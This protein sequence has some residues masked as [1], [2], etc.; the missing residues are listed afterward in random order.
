MWRDALWPVVVVLSVLLAGI[1]LGIA[2]ADASP[3]VYAIDADHELATDRAIDEYHRDGVISQNLTKLYLTVT[4]A[5]THQDAG[6][7]GFHSNFNNQFICL[8]YRE[9]IPREVRV[10]IPRDYWWPRPAEKDS[11]TS[12]SPATFEPT[13]EENHT[14]ITVRFDGPERAC[15][16]VGKEAGFYFRN[17]DRLV[18]A[19]ND[20]TGWSLPQLG[21]GE[22]Q[23][24]Y[25]PDGVFL[26]NST[27]TIP[28]KGKDMTIQYAP[29]YGNET[30]PTWLP[31]PS[32]NDPEDQAVCQY[33]RDGR[34]ES[35]ELLVTDARAPTIRYKRGR[36]LPAQLEGWAN[37]LAAVPDRLMEFLRGIGG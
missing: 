36:D 31:V 27:H 19:V 9:T 35:V 7:D 34:A 28:T 23:W 33:E 17:K 11:V 2:V 22:T 16:V 13:D 1:P 6:I 24:Q 21:G 26:N 10:Y 5:E 25:V 3:D 32:C 29:E 37:D 18:D 15:Y 12:Q 8:D 4:I 30:D 14:A 20:T